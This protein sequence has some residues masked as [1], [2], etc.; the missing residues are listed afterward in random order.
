VRALR[1]SHSAV[2]DEWRGRERAL[3]SLGVDVA[4]LSARTWPEGGARVDLHPRPGEHVDGVATIGRHPATIHFDT[5]PVK[6][7]VLPR[8]RL[9]KHAQETAKGALMDGP[10]RQAR[11]TTGQ[12]AIR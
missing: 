9:R 6:G 12:I 8:R 11:D 4:L 5:I 10:F 2:V 1:V 3:A 7:T